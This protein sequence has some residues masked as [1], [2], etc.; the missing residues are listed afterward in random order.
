MDIQNSVALLREQL[1]WASVGVVALPSAAIAINEL[2]I[3]LGFTE[4]ALGGYLIVLVTLLIA[5]LKIRDELTVLRAFMLVPVFRLVNFGIPVLFELTLYWI[6][7][8]YLSFVPALYI[9]VRDQELMTLDAG[10]IRPKLLALPLAI[11]LGFLLGSVEYY[12]LRPEA[13]IPAWSVVQLVVLSLI[14]LL[15][16]FVEE[17]LFRGVLQRTLQAR[18]GQWLGLLLASL[19][20]GLMHSGYQSIGEIGLAVVIGLVLGFVYDQVDSITLVAVTHATLN[21]FLFGVI[22][23]QGQFLPFPP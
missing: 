3:Y 19:L 16:G 6:P 22:P 12:V 21:V 23:L 13:L 5:P 8:V 20:F 10:V 11:P 15:V 9:V 2:L 17:L 1:D 18:L 4:Y 14:M 7:F